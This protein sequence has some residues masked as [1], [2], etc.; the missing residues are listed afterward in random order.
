MKTGALPFIAFFILLVLVSN[1]DIPDNKHVPATST[2]VYTT[3]PIIETTTTVPTTTTIKPKAYYYPAIGA[4]HPLIIKDGLLNNKFNVYINDSFLFVLDKN[5]TKGVYEKS[6]GAAA[7][8]MKIW[9]EETNNTV[10][11]N[12]TNNPEGAD[13]SIS[14]AAS[15]PEKFSGYPSDTIGQAI[16]SGYDCSTFKFL[17]GGSVYLTVQ[18]SEIENLETAAHE[19]GHILNLAHVGNFGNIMSA[20][21]RDGHFADETDVRNGISKDMKTTLKNITRPDAFSFC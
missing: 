10:R 8:A 13:I 9:E 4:P 21:Y 1:P 16:N 14:W 12:V 3:V 11:F 19:M 6:V 5:K 15:L 7:G 18:N 17:T 2:T 20:S